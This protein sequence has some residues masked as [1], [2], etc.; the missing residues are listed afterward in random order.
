MPPQAL[1]D[2]VLTKIVAPDT[3]RTVPPDESA[4]SNVRPAPNVYACTLS[5]PPVHVESVRSCEASRT[6]APESAARIASRYAGFT[7]TEKCTSASSKPVS[8]CATA[9][10]PPTRTGTVGTLGT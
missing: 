4:K 3:L 6:S 1:G 9:D 5:E 10:A 2:D 7:L 8:S